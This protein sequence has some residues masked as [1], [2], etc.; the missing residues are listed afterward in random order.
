MSQ[1]GN[2]L[3][4]FS[5]LDRMGEEEEGPLVPP[6]VVEHKLGKVDEDASGPASHR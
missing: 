1:C 2:L 5:L 6:G 4:S 3:D